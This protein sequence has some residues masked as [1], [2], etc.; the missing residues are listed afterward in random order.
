MGR[1]DEKKDKANGGIM[2]DAWELIG[3]AWES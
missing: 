2:D 1:G 3:F